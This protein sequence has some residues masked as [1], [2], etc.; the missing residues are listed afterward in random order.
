MA[1]VSTCTKPSALAT[2]FA[3]VLLPLALVPSMAITIARLGLV[4]S[5]DMCSLVKGLLGKQFLPGERA[6]VPVENPRPQT[7]RRRGGQ[8]LEEIRKR[9]LHAARILDLYPG[10]FQSKN[11]KT[12]GHA[13]VVVGLDFRPMEL[14]R[15]NRQRVAFL[16]HLRAAFGQLGAQGKN[17]LGF[18]DA[19]TSQNQ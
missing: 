7:V 15:E 4:G 10:N 1:P 6:P 18:L 12:H 2:S 11:G 13:M 3:L 19:E 17:T 14:G 16:D 9:L 8:L 5:C